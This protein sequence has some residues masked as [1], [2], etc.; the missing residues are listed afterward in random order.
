MVRLKNQSEIEG[1]RES[2]RLLARTLRER[3]LWAALLGGVLL[4]ALS[5][6]LVAWMHGADDV[7]RA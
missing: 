7:R 1:I 3:Q 6:R 4:W 5:G 2:G